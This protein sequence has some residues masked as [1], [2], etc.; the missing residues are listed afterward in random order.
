MCVTALRYYEHPLVVKAGDR[1][2]GDVLLFPVLRPDYDYTILQ[3]RH[4]L[5]TAGTQ[6]LFRRL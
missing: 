6:N 1:D 4:W 5:A 2:A 3:F